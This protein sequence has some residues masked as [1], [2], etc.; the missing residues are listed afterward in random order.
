MLLAATS[1]D[2]ADIDA[3]W[4]AW[5]GLFTLIGALLLVD[6]LGYPSEQAG[7]ILGVRAST[8]RALATQGRRALRVT[9]GARDA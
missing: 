7:S 2:F 3:E 9:E 6:L 8:V 4:W 5:V 1:A